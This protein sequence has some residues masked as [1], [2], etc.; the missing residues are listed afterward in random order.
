MLKLLNKY[1]ETRHLKEA[2]ALVHHVARHPMSACAALG[3]DGD[4]LR[5]AA[6]LVKTH[7]ANDAELT[8]VKLP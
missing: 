8:E 5:E 2:R 7:V 3:E 1:R 4:L 6:E